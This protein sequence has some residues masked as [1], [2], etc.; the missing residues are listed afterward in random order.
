VSRPDKEE[1]DK[2]KKEEGGGRR[3]RGEVRGRGVGNS[4]RGI[5]RD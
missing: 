5:K 3:R 2:K 4:V 1:K